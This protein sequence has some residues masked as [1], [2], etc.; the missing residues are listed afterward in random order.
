[1]RFFPRTGDSSTD[2]SEVGIADQ[3]ASQERPESTHEYSQPLFAGLRVSSLEAYIMIFQ[4]ALKHHLITKAFS[5]L[6]LLLQV[7][8]PVAKVTLPPENVFPESFSQ[9]LCN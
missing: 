1:M 2:D 9:H 7:L 4:Y 3:E 8:L 6:L 5:G